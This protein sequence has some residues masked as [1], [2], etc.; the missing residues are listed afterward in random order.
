LNNLLLTSHIFNKLLRHAYNYV[1]IR[2]I[3]C[4]HINEIHK[5]CKKLQENVSS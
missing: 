4:L 2:L 1:Y 5:Q 3:F